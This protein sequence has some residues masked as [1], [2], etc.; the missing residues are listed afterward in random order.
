MLNR[1]LHSDL[2]WAFVALKLA[3]V[4]GLVFCGII[5]LFLLLSAMRGML[6]AI[7]LGIQIACAALIMLA[8]VFITV[9]LENGD[10]CSRPAS[11]FGRRLN[12]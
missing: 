11:T 4:W 3:L 7:P 9:M 6:A 10:G 8:A 12:L 1:L 5:L 2:R